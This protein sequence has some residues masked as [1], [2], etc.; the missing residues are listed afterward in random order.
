MDSIFDKNISTVYNIFGIL[1]LICTLLNNVPQLWTTYKLRIV[2]NFNGLSLILRLLGGFF[3][4]FYAVGIS[5]LILIVS[6]IVS[7]GSSLFLCYY[8]F[9]LIVNRD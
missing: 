3:Y 1:G 9:I 2:K 5:N 7:V 6:A 4:L 8:K